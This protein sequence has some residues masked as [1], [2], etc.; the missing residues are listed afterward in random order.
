MYYYKNAEI[1]S[2]SHL[3]LPYKKPV[4]FYF[5]LFHY[6]SPYFGIV[7]SIS[8]LSNLYLSSFRY[9]KLVAKVQKPPSSKNKN[10]HTHIYQREMIHVINV[11]E[12]ETDKYIQKIKQKQ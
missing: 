7:N 8:H 6:F 11:K 12:R 10:A 2:N 4:T 9:Q 5:L 3:N 1:D